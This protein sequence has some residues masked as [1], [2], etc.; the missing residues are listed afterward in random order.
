MQVCIAYRSVA[1]FGG[2]LVMLL[3]TSCSTE[4]ANKIKLYPVRG[5]VLLNDKPPE[6]AKVILYVVDRSGEL[7]KLSQPP[8]AQV[9]ADGSF[10]VGTYGPEDGAPAGKYQV[11]IEWFPPDARAR[12]EEASAVTN[13]LPSIYSD[14]KTSRL[15]IDVKEGPND[16]PV[17]QLKSKK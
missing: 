15:E 2:I 10:S 13:L 8:S 6:G 4:D 14:P 9:K 16:V 17:F 7:G 1:L 11:G 3:L 5:K 12:M